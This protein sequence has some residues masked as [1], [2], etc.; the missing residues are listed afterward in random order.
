MVRADLALEQ[1]EVGLDQM[2]YKTN[3]DC[4][5]TLQNG[6]TCMDAFHFPEELV[7]MIFS[8]IPFPQLY[9]VRALSSYWNSNFKLFRE[10]QI[11]PFGV[12]ISSVCNNWP[13]YG[14]AF[15]NL[16]GE[17]ENEI[18]G[19]MMGFNR[20]TNSWHQ[21]PV[22]PSISSA[23]PYW[24]EPSESSE[25]LLNAHHELVMDQRKL[26]PYRY[27]SA[28]LLRPGNPTFAVAIGGA[29]VGIIR[30]TSKQSNKVLVTNWL[31]GENRVLPCPPFQYGP[32]S[33]LLVIPVGSNDYTL[34]LLDCQVEKFPS[35]FVFISQVYNSVSRIWISS[36][37]RVRDANGFSSLLTR[38][39]YLSPNSV[40]SNDIVHILMYITEDYHMPGD[41]FMPE[42]ISSMTLDLKSGVLTRQV[43]EIE[44]EED[45][46]LVQLGM[47][48]LDSRGGLSIVALFEDAEARFSR[49]SPLPKTL[50]ASEVRIYD[51]DPEKCEL[52]E[53]VRSGLGRRF[54]THLVADS[55]CIYFIQMSDVYG[56]GERAVQSF[57][58]VEQA[59]C[60]HPLPSYDLVYRQKRSFSCFQPGLNP[61]AVP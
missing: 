11:T 35:T 25:P 9:K 19:D 16:S 60:E 24:E 17:Y 61:F 6:E 22:L 13:T 3:S 15:V 45:K 32:Q 44:H 29:L 52:V 30:K 53:A 36:S 46:E 48:Q 28:E 18:I 10:L 37:F 49:H 50:S 42:E 31:T 38:E 7:E 1:K 12:G 47:F 4:C 57:N 59:W 2:G 5:R 40:Y 39:G 20:R 14:P 8:K 41:P 58:V 56:K 43:V 55:D 21:F 23:V 54:G 27:S 51:F 26:H 33:R 34:V